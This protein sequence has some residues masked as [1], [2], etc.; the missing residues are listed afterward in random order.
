MVPSPMLQSGIM[1]LRVSS[2][3]VSARMGNL[4]VVQSFDCGFLLHR[5][6]RSSHSSGSN[7]FVRGMF[8]GVMTWGG[9]SLSSIL[10]HEASCDH[11]H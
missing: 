3:F 1:L 11:I 2:V 7:C 4:S 10:I 9:Q 8:V 5:A 6:E